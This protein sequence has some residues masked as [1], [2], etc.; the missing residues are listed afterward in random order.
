[1]PTRERLRLKVLQHASL[2]LDALVARPLHPSCAGPSSRAAVIRQE[3]LIER[4]A[5]DFGMLPLL[6]LEAD[7]TAYEISYAV[8]RYFERPG[9][10]RS[11]LRIR[12]LVGMRL[13]RA[14]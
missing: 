6:Q 12:D 10:S 8:R 9:R 13:A 11:E 5:R 1:M 7:A 2:Q 3:A 4:H 14:V